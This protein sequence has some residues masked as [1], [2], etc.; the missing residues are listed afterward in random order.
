MLTEE[1]DVVVDPFAGSNTTGWVAERL[2]RRWIAIEKVEAY[3]ETSMFRF[4]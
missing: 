2:Q 3:L 1:G 4:R